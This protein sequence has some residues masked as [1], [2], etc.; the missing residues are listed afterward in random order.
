V[1]FSAK[2]LRQNK[3]LEPRDGANAKPSS[4]GRLLMQASDRR[5]AV[6][7]MVEALGHGA[8]CART[9]RNKKN[10]YEPIV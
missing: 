3:G 6:I 4:E 10:G 7:G 8:E 2:S 1:W 9:D 5:L